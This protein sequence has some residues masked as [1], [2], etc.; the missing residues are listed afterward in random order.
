MNIYITLGIGNDVLKDMFI[1]EAS[2]DTSSY[3]AVNKQDG[4]SVQLVKGALFI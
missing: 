4:D 3:T 1:V 2:L